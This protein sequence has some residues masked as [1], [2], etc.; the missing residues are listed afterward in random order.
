MMGVNFRFWKQSSAFTATFRL[1]H[2]T[3]ANS[4]LHPFLGNQLDFISCKS[5]HGSSATVG[6]RSATATLRHSTTGAGGLFGELKKFFPFAALGALQ[7]SVNDLFWN[8][9]HN[10]KPTVKPG[11]TKPWTL[12]RIHREPTRL[13][14]KNAP[15][16]GQAGYA[17]HDH[18]WLSHHSLDR[19][20][21][22]ESEKACCRC[23]VGHERRS[24]PSKGHGS[25]IHCA[26]TSRGNYFHRKRVVVNRKVSGRVIS[27]AKVRRTASRWPSC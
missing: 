14:Q 3:T 1:E 26:R 13:H 10:S 25:K 16:W 17:T 8:A 15:K 2:L 20:P 23:E 22:F 18:Y 12:L 4:I 7:L 27:S 5:R 9:P 24:C 21:P 19:C 6:H 11:R